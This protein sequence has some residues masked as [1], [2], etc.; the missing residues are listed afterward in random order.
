MCSTALLSPPVELENF[1]YCRSRSVGIF[2][3]KT[4]SRN[5]PDEADLQRKTMH[6]G[7][8]PMSLSGLIGAAP[9]PAR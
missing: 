1:Q 4:Q 6:R 2:G 5:D 8:S 7:R 9:K 3:E